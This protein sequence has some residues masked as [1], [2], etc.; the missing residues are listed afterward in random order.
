MRLNVLK[1]R[2]QSLRETTTSGEDSVSSCASRH[3]FLNDRTCFQEEHISHKQAFDD[4]T[5]KENPD[6]MFPNFDEIGR[7]INATVRYVY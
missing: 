5:D 3:S 6:C 1:R 4:L 2:A 7:L